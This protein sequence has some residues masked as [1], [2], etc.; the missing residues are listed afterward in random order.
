[1]NKTYILSKRWRACLLC[2][3]G[4]L[5]F[6]LLSFNSNAQWTDYFKT[7]QVGAFIEQAQNG[8][9]DNQGLVT[10][11]DP[12]TWIRG[13]VNESKGHYVE[14]WSIPYRVYIDGIPAAA[15]DGAVDDEGDPLHGGALAWI[16]IEYD[17]KHSGKH[18][19]D[20]IT[21]F[22]NMSNDLQPH[23]A[24]EPPHPEETVQPWDGYFALE[25]LSTEYA[26]LKPDMAPYNNVPNVL[27]P[28]GT[29][30]PS[31]CFDNHATFAQGT[32]GTFFTA[33]N[34]EITDVKINY[35][36]DLAEAQSS[37]GY[38]IYFRPWGDEV[39][40]AWGGHIGCTL[41]WGTV[42]GTPEGESMAAAGIN[43]SP[44]HMRL[45]GISFKNSVGNQDLQLS[46][47]A[48]FAPPAVGCEASATPQTCCF[49]NDGTAHA[50]GTEGLAGYTYS[51][52]GPDGFTSTEQDLTG[53]APGIYYVTICDENDPNNC[54]DC[55]A[56]VLPAEPVAPV[57]IGVPEDQD[58]GCNPTVLP[59]CADVTATVCN[60]PSY[61]VDVEC[62]E[63]IPVEGDNCIW[64][65]TF[66]YTATACG[67]PTTDFVTYTW[68]VDLDAPVITAEPGYY[69][70]C[71]PTDL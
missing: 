67:I 53:L 36:G 46:A 12:V 23:S 14:N 57:L 37:T 69:L 59:S 55:S 16:D 47:S 29:I 24:F 42:D 21:H 8:G 19:I 27:Q 62:T 54:A 35:E 40:L 20:F 65:Q 25:P 43:G 45:K 60:D 66:Q 22:Q 5:A 13:N 17:I 31:D 44:Y 71:N 18:A 2:F 7:N 1:M 56:E 39:V 6:L 70:G 9:S 10:P 28:G 41:S 68:K 50:Q 38:R 63:G 51:W 49:V 30:T 11:I 64:T 58:L 15:Q 4:M 26:V 34:A 52:T 32:H 48:V 61:P 3:A 33:Y